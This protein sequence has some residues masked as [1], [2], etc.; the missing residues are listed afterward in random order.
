MKRQTILVIVIIAVSLLFTECDRFNDDSDDSS[1]GYLRVN[2]WDLTANQKLI[3]WVYPDD[4]TLS[5]MYGDSMFSRLIADA[6]ISMN[7]FGEGAAK[8]V[9][10]ETPEPVP[11]SGWYSLFA[12]IDTNGNNEPTT[13]ESYAIKDVD[14]NGNITIDFDNENFTGT[15]P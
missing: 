1:S 6:K 14:I 5:A 10:H 13:G 8:V 4:T 15:I 12:F 11:L 3:V 2:A 9:Y 7:S